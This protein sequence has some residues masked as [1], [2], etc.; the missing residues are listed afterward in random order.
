MHVKRYILTFFKFK[1]DLWTETAG[2][3]DVLV[4]SPP[5]YYLLFRHSFIYSAFCVTEGF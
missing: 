4:T 5:M 2:G 1:Q 3:G